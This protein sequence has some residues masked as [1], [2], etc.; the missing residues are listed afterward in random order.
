MTGLMGGVAWY[1]PFSS[2][3]DI[4]DMDSMIHNF[5]FDYR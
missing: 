5:V 3:E 1:R 4:L 2:M